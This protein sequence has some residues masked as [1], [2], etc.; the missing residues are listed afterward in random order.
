MV[1][2][3]K[4]L[5]Q[6]DIQRKRSWW[7]LPQVLCKSPL[8]LL[9]KGSTLPE[10]A[11]VHVSLLRQIKLV[12]LLNTSDLHTLDLVKATQSE[13]FVAEMRMDVK[14]M[15]ECLCEAWRQHCPEVGSEAHVARRRDSSLQPQ[16]HSFDLG[17]GG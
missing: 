9:F 2:D 14:G 13:D 17:V 15:C 5:G 8:H 7:H 3:V 1:F 6:L 10:N 16:K 11:N 12:P 4:E